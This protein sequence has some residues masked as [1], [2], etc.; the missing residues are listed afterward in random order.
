MSM[1]ERPAES[2][3]NAVP[4]LH[5]FRD[6]KWG[7]GEPFFS[8]PELRQR[9]DLLRHLT[10]NSEKILLVKGVEGVGKSTLLQQFRKQAREEWDL[11]CIDANH[12]LHPD[13]LFSQLYRRFGLTDEASLSI[14]QLIKRFELLAAA[15]RLP[16]II[17]DDAHLLPVATIIAIFRL[18]ERRPG[19]RALIRVVLL[20]TPDIVKQFQTPQLQA[21]NLQSV[22]S[23]EMP[24]LDED[25]AR[26]F[27][28]FLIDLGNESRQLK[29]AGVSINRLIRDSAGV[30][31][32]IE[33]QLQRLFVETPKSSAKLPS[34]GPGK[35]IAISKGLFS[36]LPKPALIGAALLAIL[37][38]LT[39][40]FQEEINRLFDDSSKMASGE[41]ELTMDN[42]STR[43]LQLPSPSIAVKPQIAKEAGID[44]AEPIRND[45]LSK[46][47]GVDL[48]S[49]QMQEASEDEVT[50]LPEPE[51]EQQPNEPSPP[52]VQAKETL[53]DFS[54]TI[55]SKVDSQKSTS[56]ATLETPAERPAIVGEV[57]RPF[58]SGTENAIRDVIA[59]PIPAEEKP[60]SQQKPSEIA[61]VEKPKDGIRRE[62]WLSTQAPGAYTLQLIGAKDEM[63][64]K[65]FI[66]QYRLKGD[67]A[68]FKS[69]RGGQAW[70]S[71]LYGSFPDRE[72]AVKAR[73]TLP[74][75]LQK[76]D[77]WPRTFASVQ[78]AMK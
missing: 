55:S 52:D 43:P 60:L 4:Y 12:T 18:F 44:K 22:Q 78:A 17:I 65:R 74:P 20:A 48:P 34:D 2:V 46:Q 23:L 1:D 19:N 66:E 53:L 5:Q 35:P 37:L 61:S 31:G 14:E 8:T 76:S 33:H 69:I 64:V 77:A 57:A 59:V 72:T 54:Q 68:Y 42:G 6:K 10:D 28:Q 38:L 50:S 75:A 63:A 21:M 32:K 49:L 25:Q 70:F 39:L 73:G 13:Q 26:S 24:L 41:R 9:L 47:P 11:C 29:L 27:V 3:E 40:L 51:S 58:D 30:P 36:D 62:A 67:I 16:V 7:E 56:A 45:E 15:G 71:V